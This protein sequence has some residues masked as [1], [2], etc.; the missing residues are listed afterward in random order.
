MQNAGLVWDDKLAEYDLGDGH[1]LNPLR[2]KLAVDLMDACGLLGEGVVI[3]PRMARTDELELAHTRGYIEAVW[4]AGDWAASPAPGSGLGTEDNPIYPGMYEVAALTTGSTIVG[5]E[6][7]LVGN[8]RRTFSIAGGMH[9]AHK[10]RAAGFSVFNDAAVAI[11][12]ARIADPDLRVLYL[13]M[14]A[15]HGDGVQECFYGT[16]D[17]LTISV[18]Q[19]GVTAFPGTGFPSEFGYGAGEGYAVNVPLT[20]G[21]GDVCFTRV[22]DQVVAPLAASFRPGVIVAQLGVDAHYEDPQ[23]DLGLT[24]AGWA[25]LAARTIALADEMADGRLAALGGGGYHVAPIVPLAWAKL[26]SL[27]RGV[28]IGDEVPETWRGRV[29]EQTGAEPPATFSAGAADDVRERDVSALS[30]TERCVAE[31]RGAVFPFH[32]LEP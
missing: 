32:G 12:A 29:R 26:F 25:D 6:E 4:E 17:V 15:H 24:L 8:H 2:L 7:V 31:V 3:R 18:H 5:L 9:H 27:L 23:T 30:E 14:D 21:A 22:F 20:P 13:D 1:P 16:A 10:A 28:D 19:S 11:S